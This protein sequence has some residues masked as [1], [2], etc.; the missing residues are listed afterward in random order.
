MSDRS[1]LIC[2]SEKPVSG[3]GVSSSLTDKSGRIALFEALMGEAGGG[4]AF[5][6]APTVRRAAPS[7][8]WSQNVVPKLATPNSGAV[9][10]IIG[11]TPWIPD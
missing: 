5:S 6:N 3:A 10:P 1:W 9:G 7:S 8:Q 2:I 11:Q 4:I